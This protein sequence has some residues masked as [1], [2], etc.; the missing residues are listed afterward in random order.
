MTSKLINIGYG[1]VIRENRVICIIN[2][3]SASSKRL[4]TEAKEAH[5]LVDATQGRKTR[6]LII[7]DTNHVILSSM[8]P[9]T[10]SARI[11]SLD[12]NLPKDIQES[13]E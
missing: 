2:P 13:K 8:Q 1:N 4:R 12:N 11:N 3:D 9:E 10:I 7:T 6:A 5:L